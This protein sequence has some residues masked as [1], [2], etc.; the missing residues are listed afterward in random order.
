MVAYGKFGAGDIHGDSDIFAKAIVGG[1]DGELDELERFIVAVF[2]EWSIATLVANGRGILAIFE[3]FLEIVEYLS[4][5]ANGV[6]D[7]TCAY[8]NN[9]VF[10]EIGRPVGVCATVHDIHHRHWET[11]LVGSAGNFGDIFVE[12]NAF[13]MR[14]G[15]CG[16][17]RNGQDSVSAK[18]GFVFGAVEIKHELVDLF[19]VAGVV[20]D[21]NIGD[22][23]VDVPDSLECAFAEVASFVAVAEL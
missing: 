16:S 1:F 23:V 3:D 13:S 5:H 8:W 20:A 15:F 4:T 2:D 12:A 21:K 22:F 18:I 19:L 17:E 6:V 7:V 10:L 11:H 9:H 14:D